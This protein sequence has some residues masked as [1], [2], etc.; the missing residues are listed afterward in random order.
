MARSRSEKPLLEVNLSSVS[1]KNMAVF[2]Q[3]KKT[4]AVYARRQRFTGRSRYDIATV[5]LERENFGSKNRIFS[6]PDGTRCMAVQ[7]GRSFVV[8]DTKTGETLA[9]FGKSV[10]SL[11]KH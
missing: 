8:S 4:P 5:Q 3:S 6:L 7:R 2:E 11:R 1:K 9:T 10:W